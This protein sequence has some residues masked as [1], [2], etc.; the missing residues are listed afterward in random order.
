MTDFSLEILTRLTEIETRIGSLES[1][2]FGNGQP[3]S[4]AHLSNRVHRLER[5]LWLGVGAVAA[6]SALLGA[7]G[8]E[9]FK[10]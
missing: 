1:R 5:F 6:F 4:L 2:L 7:G 10:R 9:L 3:G 8:I